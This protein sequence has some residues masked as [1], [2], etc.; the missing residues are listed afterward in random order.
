M[1]LLVDEPG[2]KG[3]YKLSQI[4]GNESAAYSLDLHVYHRHPPIRVRARPRAYQV[5]CPSLCSSVYLL[6]ASTGLFPVYPWLDQL[7]LLLER[8]LYPVVGC[9]VSTVM[10]TAYTGESGSRW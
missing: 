5:Q 1:I 10:E 6:F 9:R 4:L 3:V 7:L 8:M 2:P